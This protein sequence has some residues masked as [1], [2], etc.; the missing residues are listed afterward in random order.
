MSSGTTNTPGPY[1]DQTTPKSIR[2]ACLIGAASWCKE[3]AKSNEK[4]QKID[5]SVDFDQKF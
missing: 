4:D 3:S 1:K 5:F 2:A